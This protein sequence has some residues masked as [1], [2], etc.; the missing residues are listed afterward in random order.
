[1]NKSELVGKIAEQA[2]VTSAQA[3][4][5]V[6]ALFSSIVEAA[7][8]GDKVAWPGFGSFSVSNR[9]A[10][11]GRNPQTGATIEIAASRALRFSP[12]SAVKTALN[13]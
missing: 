10:R 9:A 7:K 5:I 1:L 11:S 4:Q 6:G 8:G 2:G 12:A 13:S 3:E